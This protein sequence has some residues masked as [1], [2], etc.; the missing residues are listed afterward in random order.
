MS[1][2]L[3]FTFGAIFVYVSYLQITYI[4][5][6]CRL[7]SKAIRFNLYAYALPY[8]KTIEFVNRQD[9]IKIATHYYHKIFPIFSK[10]PYLEEKFEKLKT[11]NWHKKKRY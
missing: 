10:L 9:L 1:I 4:T 11:L 2:F 6:F 3:F 5:R 8:G 7:Y